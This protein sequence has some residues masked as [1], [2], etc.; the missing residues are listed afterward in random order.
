MKPGL[1]PTPEKYCAYCGKKMERKTYPNS[2]EDLSSFSR[3]KYCGIE[4]MRKAYVKKGE[5]SQLYTA[6]HHSSRK[7]VYLIEDREK[8]CELCGTTI[9]IDV[10]HKDGNYRNNRSENL[11][12]VCRSCH[13]KLHHPK[14]K[15][16]ICG[17]PVKGHGYC[18]KHYQRFKKY[19]DPNH[20]PWSTYRRKSMVDSNNLF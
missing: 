15:C 14:A 1:K 11:M 7:V 17:K 19:G 9:N 6:A 3:R 12:V 2:K 16:R 10:H 13:M 20:R 8:K 5:N 18:E 4:C